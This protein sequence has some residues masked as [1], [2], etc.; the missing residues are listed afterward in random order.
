MYTANKNLCLLKIFHAIYLFAQLPY[1]L[2]YD[3]NQKPIVFTE[4]YYFSLYLD[5]LLPL[6]TASILTIFILCCC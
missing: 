6:S 2:Q 1:E 4:Y 5:C 3:Q